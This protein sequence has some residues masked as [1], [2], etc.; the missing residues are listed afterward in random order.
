MVYIDHIVHT[1]S[2][3]AHEKML[4]IANY[5]RNANQNYNEVITSHWL[6][7]S[8]PKSLQRINAGEC[9]EKGTLLHCWWEYKLMQLL[10][11]TVWRFLKK[12]KRRATKG[13]ATHSSILAWRIPWKEEPGGIQSKES[14]TTEQLTHNVHMT[15]Q[16]HTWVYTQ[17]KTWFKR[18]QAPQCL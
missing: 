13:K 17:R 6:E 5:L 8:S 11:R 18:I 15:L 4:H 7:W 3:E 12:T 14:D 10:W 2:Q 16:S 9:G 1:H